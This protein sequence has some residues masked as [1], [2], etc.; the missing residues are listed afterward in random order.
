MGNYKQSQDKIHFFNLP[1]GA[2]LDAQI[3]NQSSSLFLWLCLRNVH[4]RGVAMLRKQLLGLAPALFA[5]C[6]FGSGC[7]SAKK[8]AEEAL[9]MKQME[10][11]D[12]NALLTKTTW[13][14]TVDKDMWKIHGGFE[15]T[16]NFKGDLGSETSIP[17]PFSLGTNEKFANKAA[18]GKKRMILLLKAEEFTVPALGAPI[19]RFR[20]ASIAEHDPDK[21][22]L[23]ISGGEVNKYLDEA[24][25]LSPGKQAGQY[26]IAEGVGSGGLA[27]IEGIARIKAT[28]AE[29]APLANVMVFTS[30]SPFVTL[31]GGSGETKGQYLLAMLDGSKG[32]VTGYSSDVPK[33]YKGTSASVSTEI[34][35]AGAL[36]EYKGDMDAKLAD[37]GADSE[38]GKKASSA[39]DKLNSAVTPY[40]GGWKL[41]KI[42]LLFVQPPAAPPPP[43]TAASAP[44]APTPDTVE[45]PPPANE[46]APVVVRQDPKDTDVP[47]VDLG[48]NGKNI[49]GTSTLLTGGNDIADADKKGWRASGD[50][51][52]T[53]ENHVAIFGSIESVRSEAGDDGRYLDNTEGYCLLTTGDAQYQKSEKA[54][55]QMI[56]GPDGAGKTS[57]MWQA[58]KIPSKESNVKS[59]Q[60][61]VAF[62]TQEFP[63]YVGTKFNDSF[64]IK[65]DELPEFL[66]EGNLNDLAG[67]ADAAADCKTKTIA[68]ADTQI[69]CGE[70][71][72]IAG[73][74]KM[75]NLGQMWD[76]DRSSQAT[77]SGTFHCGAT[78]CYHGFIRPRI[79]CRDLTDN[80][81]DKTLTLR[82]AVTDAGDNIFDSALAVD[83]VIFSTEACSAGTFTGEEPSRAL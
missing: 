16:D 15:L 3:S 79:I 37:V 32:Q 59:I 67:G 64:Y 66:A 72:S 44:P 19:T 43:P 50:V 33:T 42:D 25:K 54:A 82:F 51:L 31:S 75:N 6:M 2:I 39:F 73:D 14:T 48:C 21:N 58:V 28:G 27:F 4:L 9:G 46:P 20:I 26:L 45:D 24:Q 40:L 11:A 77:N 63:K 10:D 35:Y 18:E 7:D 70:W 36:D 38:Q 69:T 65:F 61:R 8:A 34:A 57:E 74:A 53:A 17:L 60:M 80:H 1:F 76:I 71:Y 30:S 52:I 68:S 81:F 13:D 47:Q 78:K 5:V 41:I 55:V 22:E 29:A 12:K 49:D 23:K 56:P 62:F 83:S